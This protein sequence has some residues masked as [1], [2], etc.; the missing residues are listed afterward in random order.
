MYVKN[1]KNSLG[2]VI[3]SLNVYLKAMILCTF[4]N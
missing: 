1:V 3:Y 2:G 4:K